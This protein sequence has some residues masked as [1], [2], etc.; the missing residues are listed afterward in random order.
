MHKLD[1]VSP[2]WREK[3]KRKRER[4]LK[5][6]RRT[7]AALSHDV[8]EPCIMSWPHYLST[9]ICLPLLVS[10]CRSSYLAPSLALSLFRHSFPCTSHSLIN[11]HSLFSPRAQTC[12]CDCLRMKEKERRRKKKKEIRRK[13]KRRERG[14]EK[15]EKK[16]RQRSGLNKGR[17]A[18]H[19]TTASH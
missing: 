18:T 16:R 2:R 5:G 11:T 1:P 6:G 8:G 12:L 9:T 3:R 15:R 19:C 14:G 7:P 4:A 13:E 17:S 10:P